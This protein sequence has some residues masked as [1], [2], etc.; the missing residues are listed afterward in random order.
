MTHYR[1]KSPSTVPLI[2]EIAAAMVSGYAI[3]K[4]IGSL[5]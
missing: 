3:A 2:V 1:R 5:L 4:L